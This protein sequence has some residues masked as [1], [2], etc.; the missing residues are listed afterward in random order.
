[1]KYE[2]KVQKF[3]QAIVKA[4]GDLRQAA[5]L[6]HKKHKLNAADSEGGLG[7][8]QAAWNEAVHG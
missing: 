5:L 8:D 3:K 1:M 6:A 7:S 4:G 2:T